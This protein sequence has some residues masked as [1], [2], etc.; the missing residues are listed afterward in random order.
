MFKEI[1]SLFYLATIILFIFFTLKYYFSDSNKKKSY[2]IYSNINK[3]IILYSKNLPILETNTE[4]ILEYVKEKKTKKKRY[5]FWK[6]L[7]NN[8]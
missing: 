2:R 5:N 1:K 3:K 7:D 6:L 4:N 8:D